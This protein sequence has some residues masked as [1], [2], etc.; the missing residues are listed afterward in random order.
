M[1]TQAEFI[2]RIR[3]RLNEEN[4]ARQWSDQN[5][6]GWINEGARD[7]A[8]KTE[9]LQ[10]RDTIPAVVGTAEYSFGTDAI[11]IYRVE[12]T[13]IGERTRPL[14]YVDVKSMDNYGWEQRDRRNSYP[15]VFTVFGSGRTLKLICFPAP[16]TAGN[17]TVWFYK[18]PADLEVINPTDANEHVEIPPGWDDILLDYVEYRALRKD[19]DARWTESKALYD[20]N[21]ASMYDNTRRLVEDAGMITPGVGGYLP[22]WLTSFNG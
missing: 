14:E 13:P 21:L 5:L 20:E 3:E 2:T 9:S 7:I 19:R 10:D 12:F 22:N 4:G 16:E 8:R 15:S 18:L 6:R 1:T 11:R 17:F